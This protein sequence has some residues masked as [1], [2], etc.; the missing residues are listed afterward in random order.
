[1]VGGGEQLVQVHAGAEVS[2][3]AAQRHDAN[4]GIQVGLRQ[5]R[6]ERVD[7]RDVDRVALV[8]TIQRRRKHAARQSG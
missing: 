1:V 5:H 7:H 6:R 3:G 8:G 4:V 2:T